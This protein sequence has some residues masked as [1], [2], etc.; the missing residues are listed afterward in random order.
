M[1]LYSRW[2]ALSLAT[3]NQIAQHFNIPKKGA[4][5]VVSNEIKSD[6]YLIED[7]ES[8]LTVDSMK[9]FLK[10]DSIATLQDG[11]TKLVN[12]IEGNEVE[13]VASV[14]PVPPLE[15]LPAD[16]VKKATK[17]RKAR[18]AKPKVAKPKAVKKN[19]KTK[20]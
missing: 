16:E 12:A 1:L 20:K 7:I 2:C 10:D 6:G 5:E 18:I 14:A 17:E 8:A 4:T 19:A 13:P 15:V 9:A 3:R 11:W